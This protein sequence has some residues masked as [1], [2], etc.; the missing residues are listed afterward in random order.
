MSVYPFAQLME[1]TYKPTGS[2]VDKPEALFFIGLSFAP[3]VAVIDLKHR[4]SEFLVHQINSWEGRKP[5]MDF[6]IHHVV[7]KDLPLQLISKYVVTKPS[8]YEIPTPRVI[9][10]T[11]HGSKI[12]QRNLPSSAGTP[13][14][15]RSTNT[16]KT[17]ISKDIRGPSVGD[18]VSVTRSTYSSIA[19]SMNSSI[20]SVDGTE[21]SLD[22]SEPESRSQSPLGNLITVEG[23][24]PTLR[25]EERPKKEET[26]QGN[27]KE[28][29]DD[30]TYHSHQS[31]LYEYLT[32]KI[33][34]LSS[35]NN[36]DDSCCRSQSDQSS[37]RSPMKKRLR[38]GSRG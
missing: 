6:I 30:A 16:K 13:T 9:D 5:G 14:A 31:Q 32:G 25:A 8:A 19:R 10:P 29:H 28:C 27:P 23:G 2:T 4:T 12:Q 15:T 21:T 26:R 24:P 7:Q 33:D 17:D 34:D 35:V 36:G 18:N 3:N 11:A 20:R 38:A 1:Q 37:T 22:G